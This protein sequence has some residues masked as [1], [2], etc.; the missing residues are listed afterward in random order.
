MGQEPTIVVDVLQRQK[1]VQ[2][3][4]YKRISNQDSV[5]TYYDFKQQIN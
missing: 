3:S 1:T 4:G 2:L 5:Y